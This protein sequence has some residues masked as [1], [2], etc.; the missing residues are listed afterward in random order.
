MEVDRTARNVM[1]NR[2]GPWGTSG[3][4]VGDAPGA[5]FG[6]AA[7]RL[8]PERVLARSAPAGWPTV[9]WVVRAQ[10]DFT[11]EHC[12]RRRG[13]GGLGEEALGVHHLDGDRF[14]LWDWNL[15]PLWTT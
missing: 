15:V 2:G 12:G 1:A 9:S 10:A 8:A 14:N 5:G 13:P 3:R 6:G 11:C 4:L 7:F